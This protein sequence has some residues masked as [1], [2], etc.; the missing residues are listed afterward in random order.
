M[1]ERDRLELLRLRLKIAKRQFM[2]RADSRVK[3]EQDFTGNMVR[4]EPRVALASAPLPWITP[5]AASTATSASQADATRTST[6]SEAA[7]SAPGQADAPLHAAST[8]VVSAPSRGT[9]AYAHHERAAREARVRLQETNTAFDS[10]DLD[11]TVR[12]LI[13][14]LTGVQ[15]KPIRVNVARHTEAVWGATTNREAAREA[16]A[17]RTA[18][19]VATGLTDGSRSRLRTACRN[20]L[21]FCEAFDFNSEEYTDVRFAMFVAFLSERCKMSTVEQYLKSTRSSCK[22][23]G[24]DLPAWEDMPITNRALCGARY[25]ESAVKGGYYRMP[26]TLKV[27]IDILRSA[28]RRAAAADTLTATDKGIAGFPIRRA[29]YLLAFFGA[30]RPGEVSL[31]EQKEGTMSLPLIFRYL[32]LSEV[33]N[34][35]LGTVVRCVTLY[36]PSSKADRYGQRSDIAIGESGMPKWCAVDAVL[37]LTRLRQAAGEEIGDTSFLFPAACGTRAVSY[38]EYTAAIKEDLA[39]AGYDVTKFTGH[40]MRIGCATTLAANNVP[41]HLIQAIGRWSSDCYKRY[42]RIPQERRAGLSS[43]LI[44]PYQAGDTT[45][46]NRQQIWA[47]LLA[48]SLTE[49]TPERLGDAAAPTAEPA[50]VPTTPWWTLTSWARA[51]PLHV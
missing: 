51:A 2:A 49:S 27:L 13:A 21:H 11:T 35:A 15:D 37:D 42:I 22:E 38:C 17:E 39:D 7:S 12:S 6:S 34:E 1:A 31:R 25:A 18:A 40:S 33:P 29:M 28:E 30:M 45:H 5:E 26:I 16:L 50:A 3:A 23:N 8:T 43:F 24:I 19:L 46:A 4:K 14:T 47:Q 48:L 41:D 32:Q 20:W 36:L 44:S 9:V 10:L